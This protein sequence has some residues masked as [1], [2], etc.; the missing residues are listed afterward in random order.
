[1][2][3]ND[4]N[5]IPI[6]NLNRVSSVK[7]QEQN[8]CETEKKEWKFSSF[9][10][11][12]YVNFTGNAP[13]V[14]K[15]TIVSTGDEDIVIPK[16]ENGGYIVEPETQ[17]EFIY[18]NDAKKFLNKTNKFEYD[19]QITFPSKAKG[20][21]TIDGKEIKIKENSTLLLNKGTEAKVNIESGY[22]QILMTKQD[23]HWYCKHGRNENNVDLKNKFNELIYLNSHSYNGEF[24]SKLF[25]YDDNTNNYLACKLRDNGFVTDTK[26]GYIKFCNYPTWDYQKQELANKGFN[27]FDLNAIEP[28][29]K[30][31]RQIK[32]DSKV[33]LR[34]STNGMPK[35]TLK[36]L[37]DTGVVFDNKKQTDTIFWKKNYESEWELRDLL[38]QKTDIRG[39]EQ[40][41]VINAWKYQNLSG[42]DLTGLKFINNNAALYSMEDKANN[43]GLSKSCWLTNSTALGSLK[44]STSIGTSIVQSDRTEPTPMS[45][46]REGE[47]LHTHPGYKDKSQTEIY[48]I[49]SGSAALTVV[50]NGKPQIKILREGELAVIPPKTPHCVNSVMG[51]YEQVVSQIPSCF[52]YGFG[53]KEMVE[54]PQGYSEEQLTEE[55]RKELL[56][57]RA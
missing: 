52:Q 23:Y 49:T 2:K 21:L 29:Y 31:V 7:K 30:R 50:R 51:E 13:K 4:F 33:T 55:A 39:E 26:D 46:L 10:F 35:S 14:T 41:S 19:T 9:P 53:F 34:T 1:M 5:T 16:T 48:M 27:D 3:I 45:A 32:I 57:T 37:K 28:V 11:Q 25:G 47:H 15:A 18:G 44:G 42:Y 6:G 12:N 20:S 8:S 56:K 36:K 24:K 38:N 17:T 22:P 40:D 54:L 43:W